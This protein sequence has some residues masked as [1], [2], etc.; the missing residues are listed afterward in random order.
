MVVVLLPAALEVQA[1]VQ[2]RFRQRALSIQQQGDEQ[3]AEPA[4]AVEKRVDGCELNVRKCRLEQG[5]RLHG[6]AVQEPFEVAH[7]LDDLVCRRRHESSISRT[8]AS[9]P[10]L[11][12]AEL[13][14]SLVA[15]AP[16]PEE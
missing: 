13:A 11:A 9:D 10:D 12:T 16:A 7:A 1:Q 4:I 8:R 14:R 15:S 6:I 2:D 5:W 3:P